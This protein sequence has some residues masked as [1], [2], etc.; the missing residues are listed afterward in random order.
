MKKKLLA[1]SVCFISLFSCNNE[2]TNISSRAQLCALSSSPE[3]IAIKVISSQYGNSAFTKSVSS[4]VKS[5]ETRFYSVKVPQEVQMLSNNDAINTLSEQDIPV[6]FINYQDG[7]SIVSADP[8]IPVIF[9]HATK[10]TLADTLTNEGLDMVIKTIP[11]VCQKY[12]QEFYMQKKSDVRSNNDVVALANRIEEVRSVEDGYIVLR[13]YEYL[14]EEIT[15]YSPL[16]KTRWGQYQPF[17]GSVKTLCSNTSGRA[18][19]GCG[20][21]AMGQICN[22]HRYLGVGT[23]NWSILDNA[24]YTDTNSEAARFI[25]NI[26]LS[27]H[28]VYGCD[29]STSTTS[30]TR[31][32]FETYGY[33]CSSII[34]GFDMTKAANAIAIDKCPVFVRGG[35]S[36]TVGHAWVMDGYRK[37]YQKIYV[38]EWSK[39]MAHAIPDL[40][41]VNDV[42]EVLWENLKYMPGTSFTTSHT[43]ESVHCNWGQ[44]GNSDGFCSVGHFIYNNSQGGKNDYNSDMQMF[45]PRK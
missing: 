1:F 17:N 15:E 20:A 25:S 4:Q 7:Y 34:N 35:K 14:P 44:Y 42:D 8:R 32:A 2:M 22:Y 24:E 23:Y 27:I 18:P 40:S 45:I 16:L 41:D 33:T 19:A 39:Y 13:E 28:M 29:G 12:L 6:C 37:V 36:G 10:G 43:I 5:T 31:A 11:F 26:G 30:N 38:T 9:T 21:I 3:E